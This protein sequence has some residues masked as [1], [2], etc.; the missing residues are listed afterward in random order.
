MT[1]VY[2]NSTPFYMA[3]ISGEKSTETSTETFFTVMD[4]AVKFCENN[5]GFS[6]MIYYKNRC[7]RVNDTVY[8]AGICESIGHYSDIPTEWELVSE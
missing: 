8:S 3:Y 7:L 4:E 1:K 2:R 5:S 6:W